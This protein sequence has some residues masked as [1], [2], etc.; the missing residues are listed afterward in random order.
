MRIL[1]PPGG[2][3]VITI[4]DISAQGLRVRCSRALPEGTAVE[5][6][7]R[8]TMITGEIRYSRT[9]DANNVH[10]GIQATSVAGKNADFDLIT[11]FPD[12]IRH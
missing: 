9:M 2:A 10:I 6:R 11:L 7:C 3:F 12:L 4:L 5:I 1:G 8:R